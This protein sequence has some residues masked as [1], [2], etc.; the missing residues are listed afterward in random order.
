MMPNTPI[1][2]AKW[3]QTKYYGIEMMPPQ[4]YAPMGK[5]AFSVSCSGEIR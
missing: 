1:M 4:R 2:A 5:E 3:E